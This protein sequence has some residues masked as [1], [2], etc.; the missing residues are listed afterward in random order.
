MKGLKTLLAGA[1][2]VPLLSSCLNN[3]NYNAQVVSYSSNV[4]ANVTKS[5][6]VVA[7]LGSW[8][9]SVSDTSW[10][11]PSVMKGNATKGYE[12]KNLFF[13]ANLTGKARTVT[14]V[15]SDIDHPDDASARYT[16]TQ[17]ATNSDGSFGAAPRV[18]GITGTDGSKITIAYNDSK[19]PTSIKMVKGDTVYSDLQFSGWQDSALVV[20]TEKVGKIYAGYQL[21]TLVSS[22]DTSLLET[23]QI[24][25]NDYYSK[26]EWHKR[27][28]D[29]SGYS[30]LYNN[31]AGNYQN[32]DADR[33]ADSVKYF[34]NK[35]GSPTKRVY[36]KM[37]YGNEDNRWQSVDVNHLLLGIEECN[38]YMLLGLY[39]TVRS[40][41]IMTEASTADGKYTMTVTLNA[42][43][44]V[45]TAT[46]TDRQGR[47][48]T[49]TFTYATA[50][51]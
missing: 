36:M 17:F 31:Q 49:Y 2:M 8:Q 21:G 12:A 51:K 46:V 37:A 23:R 27:G 13:A 11:R 41:K 50:G 24:A 38:P 42:D 32:P 45:N 1:L 48:V 9:L 26:L 15:V 33:M 20:N 39:P 18:S 30:M 7:S 5:Y 6:F 44:S 4:F 14:F 43:K 34:R 22:R 19:L 47:Q 25:Q 10:C 35:V 40:S 16:V 29:V 28:N 3:D